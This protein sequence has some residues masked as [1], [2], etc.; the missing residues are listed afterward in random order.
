MIAFRHDRIAVIGTALDKIELVAVFRTHFLIP[1]TPFA[2]KGKPQNIAVAQRP[3]LGKRAFLV[4][5][6]IVLGDAAVRI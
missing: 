1:Q 2:I 3:D 5:K 4:D 6:G